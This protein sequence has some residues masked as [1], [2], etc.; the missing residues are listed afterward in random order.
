LLATVPARQR[1]VEVIA[2]LG[3]GH[4][5]QHRYGSGLLIGGR[6]ALTSAHVVVEAA[7]VL[8]RRADK[9]V[10]RVDLQTALIGDPDPRRLDLAIF[11]VPDAAELPYVPVALVDR[12]GPISAFIEGCAAVGYPVFQEVV[13]DPTGLLIR[14]TAQVRGHIAP[15]SDLGEK[16]LSLEVTATPHE[17]PP[18]G[19]TLGADSAWEGMS[20]AAVFAPDASGG[21]ELLLGV[22]AEHAPRRGQSSITV[23]PLD[24][25]ADKA[26]APANARAWWAR[27]GVTDP[28][29][30]RY[31]TPTTGGSPAELADDVSN[32]SANPYL[33]LASYTYATRAFYGGP[34]PLVR[35]AVTRLMAVDDEPVMVFV[36]G[37]SGSGKSS[38]VQAG[39]L[40]ALEEAYAGQGGAVRWTVTR[41]GRHPIAALGRA[42]RELHMAAD[43][44]AGDWSSLLRRPE[45]LNHLL[46]TQI[47]GDNVN[48]LIIDQFEELFT[49]A[50]P[51][52]RDVTCAL[53][54]G[55][56]PFKQV[57]THVIASLRDDYLPSLF[58]VKTLFERCKRDGLE[59]R[60]MSTD[61]LA[62]AIRQPLQTQ[63]RV[64]RR[65][66]KRIDP[67]LVERLVED[68]GD[69]PTLL[70]LLQVT[71]RTLWDEPPHRLA[72]ERYRSLTHALE[73][74][75]NQVF[76]R[77]RRG[78]ERPAA[79]RGQFM[80]VFLDL[81]EVSLDDD[82]QRD[83][84]RTVPKLELLEGHPERA[85]LI[86]ELVDARLVATSA[87][88]GR[89]SD[90]E[91]VDIIHET[92]LSNWPRLRDAI[93]AERDALQQRER[94]LLALRE[95]HHSERS[96]GYLLRGVRLAEARS[97]AHRNDIALRDPDGRVFLEQSNHAEA[98]A[99]TRELRQARRR[100]RILMVVAGVAT[101]F[102]IIAAATAG[103]AFFERNTA[104]AAQ[105]QAEEQ[106]RIA[107]SRQLAAQAVDHLADQ[108]DLGLLLSVQAYRTNPTVESRGAQLSVLEF[109]SSLD[110]FL[111]GHTGTV[112]SVAFS[113]DGKTLA[114][115]SYDGTVRLWDVS[116]PQAAMFVGPS[117][118]SQNANV[119]SVAFSPH[120]NMLA[121]A[122]W[123]GTVRLWDVTNRDAVTSIGQL[124]TT[125]SLDSVAFSPD[126]KTLASASQDTIQLWDVSNPSTA[127]AIGQP[128]TGHTDFVLSVAFSP[129]GKTLASASQDRTVRLWDVGNAQAGASIG[130]PLAGHFS[131]VYSVA[132]S[133]D[134]KTL[135]SG[136]ADGTARLWDVSN[137]QAAASIGQPLTGHT[138]WVT[139]VAFSPDG[140]TLASASWDRTVRLWDV[141]N[142]REGRVIGQ[143][144]TGHTDYVWS[145]AIS[146]DGKTLASA[147]QDRTVRLWDI[148][149]PHAATFPSAQPLTAHA[150][151]VQSVAFSPNGTLA[152][153]GGD[154]T[155]RLWDVGNPQAATSIGQPLTG[156]TNVVSSVAFSPNGKTLASASYDR[157]V[158]LWDVTNPQ[159]AT[160]LGQPLDGHA[161]VYSVAFSPDGK[162]LASGNFDG[163]VQLWNV[164]DPQA[165]TPV[166]QP[167][168]QTV[169]TGADSVNSVAFSPDGKT[170][171]S[172]SG[173]G[174]V[175]LWDVSNPQAATSIGLPLTGHT[176]GLSSV[177]FSPDGKTLA[178]A[179]GDGTVRLWNVSN[180][181][182]AT[183][184][185][186][187]LTGYTEPVESVAFSPDGKLLASAGA[188]RTVRLWDVSNPQAAASIGPPLTGHT[189]PVYSV[190]FSPD[191][192]TLASGS[193]DGTVRLWD[194]SEDSWLKRICRIA[195]RNLTEA[196]WSTAMG[197]DVGYKRTC[198]DLPPGNGAPADAQ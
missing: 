152:S 48:V 164:G 155:L 67:A 177:A 23:L 51:V 8:V 66:D 172:T 46:A 121:S 174:V 195:N 117:L 58:R 84:R 61:E 41:P 62:R 125:Q 111:Y 59:L 11:E 168:G 100:A 52:E 105:Q 18:A 175:R 109:S 88:H 163:T 19:T 53:L 156:H 14:A 143:S 130:Q 151:G 150:K 147:S 180:P 47:Q 6:Y 86:E 15:L 165:V 108:P 196:E 188:D 63:A 166:G 70:P 29:H 4:T 12:N 26:T 119:Y 181:R 74:H 167:L 13:R 186:Q 193:F 89:E 77:D 158:R 171:A 93:A 131:S 10:M 149:T 36:T 75:A 45:D 112:R 145:V 191:G 50:D 124:R 94:F 39:L 31:L 116:N 7:E 16:L 97:L 20:G 153:A 32:L 37:A 114:S 182:T 113:P 122:S 54:S 140:K 157:T 160:P 169:L 57:R 24:R 87:E 40:P 194:V 96:S 104:Q 118:S 173:D 179:S 71:L 1:V 76:E 146:P 142:A 65:S 55:L 141:G 185:G 28:E 170:L 2:N 9:T 60:A 198:P 129:D 44:D 35:E 123:D 83:V 134:G 69:D 139:S 110:R 34:E 106:T 126:G 162:T 38:F 183:S 64:D 137:P 189:E 27:L 82:P 80:S 127:S 190:A 135:A 73:Q 56:A 99:H 85:E 78:H 30:L 25:L 184:I 95:W 154:S 144:L 197:A 138:N 159:A 132:F 161:I 102:A 192:K 178:S 3:A 17:L 49:Q 72:L 79:E 68:V 98:S 103:F 133:P 128:L 187:P 101:L 115:A 22:V 148:S 92:L 43:T 5:P 91:V 21:E 136:S 120:G 81:V 90:V 42:L 176:N 33:G 107:L